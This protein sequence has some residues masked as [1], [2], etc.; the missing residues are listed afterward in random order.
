MIQGTDSWKHTM[1][2]GFKPMVCLPVVFSRPWIST[3]MFPLPQQ[4]PQLC[5]GDEGWEPRGMTK[6]SSPWIYQRKIRWIPKFNQTIRSETDQILEFHGISWNFWLLTL[7]YLDN[8]RGMGGGFPIA[9]ARSCASLW[10][11]AG[12]VQVFL[13]GFCW[14]MGIPSSWI[15]SPRYFWLVVIKPS[16]KMW[17]SVGMMTSHIW[18]IK[19]VFESTNQI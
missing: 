12:A 6:G 7:I 4:H 1:F 15:A 8:F 19:F 13:G 3:L 16:W 9:M 2:A 11:P 10:S 14:F 17:K 5:R 18:K